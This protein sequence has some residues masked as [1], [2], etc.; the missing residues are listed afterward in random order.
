[1]KKK[2]IKIF[3]LLVSAVIVGAGIFIYVKSN[4]F[5]RRLKS[6][7]TERLSSYTQKQVSIDRIHTDILNRIVLTN[8][9]LKD[10]KTSEKLIK[11]K[12]ARISYSLIKFL[13]KIRNIPEL[14][15]EIHFFEPELTVFYRE[16]QIAV[17]GLEKVFTGSGSEDPLPPWK[18]EFSGGKIDIRHE[19]YPPADITNFRGEL[20]LASYPR[21][22]GDV[23]FNI[24]RST[25]REIIEDLNV[26]LGYNMVSR[27]FNTQL[28]TDNFRMASIES[29]DFLKQKIEFRQGVAGGKVKLEG[30]VDEIIED[31][32]NIKGSGQITLEDTKTGD[33][34]L[35]KMDLNISPERMLI[36]RGV[37]AWKENEFTLS[38]RVNNYLTDPN[39]D[40]TAAGNFKIAEFLPE[41]IA[42]NSNDSVDFNGNFK[43][44]PGEFKIDGDLVMDEGEISGY[45]VENFKTSVLYFDNKINFETGRLEI[46]DGNLMWDGYIKYPSK[47][48][49]L[50][51]DI[52][53]VNLEKIAKSDRFSGVADGKIKLEQ[54]L[55]DPLFEGEINFNN[56]NIYGKTFSTLNSDLQYSNKK[57]TAEGFSVDN[58]YDFG[59]EIEF[60]R[61]RKG[62]VTEFF[63]NMPDR[64][65]LE[66]T[67]NLG[68][69]PFTLDLALTATRVPVD[70][71]SG[72]N[73]RYDDPAGDFNYDGTVKVENSKTVLNGR[74]NTTDLILGGYKYLINTDLEYKAGRGV[75]NLNLTDFKLNE[76]LSGNLKLV[77]ENDGFK[78]RSLNVSAKSVKL[79]PLHYLTGL[80]PDIKE[81][82]LN[83]DINYTPEFGRLLFNVKKLNVEG[84]R[85]GDMYSVIE[86]D[87][88]SWYVEKLNF[89]GSKGNINLEGDLYPRQSLDIIMDKYNFRDRV[90]TGTGYYS[91]EVSKGERY[92]FK[93][94][95]KNLN[96]SRSSWPDITANGSYEKEQLSIDLNARDLINGDFTVSPKTGKNLSG[97]FRVKNLTMGKINTLINIQSGTLQKI[98]GIVEGIFRISDTIQ[99]PLVSFQGEVTGGEWRKV[100]FNLRGKSVYKPGTSLS[101]EETEGRIG[102]GKITAAG[103]LDNKQENELKVEVRNFDSKYLNPDILES[104]KLKAIVDANFIFSGSLDSPRLN[105]DIYSKKFT[106]EGTDIEQVEINGVLQDREF[107]L[108]RAELFKSDG[109]VILSDSNIL[110]NGG[111]KYEFRGRGKFEN[112]IVKPVTILGSTRLNGNFSMSPF[113]IEINLEPENLL[114]NRLKIERPISVEYGKEKL[115]LN[116]KEGIQADV[117]FRSDDKIVVEELNY[118]GENSSIT[119]A[120]EFGTG[121][122]NLNLISKNIE[123]NKFIKIMDSPLEFFGNSDFKVDVRYSED[124]DLK[125]IG[126]MEVRNGSY[127]KIPVDRI[128]GKFNYSNGELHIENAKIKDPNYLNLEIDGAMGESSPGLDVAVKRLSLSV[129]KL[130]TEEI[131]ESSGYF[132]GRFNIGGTLKD[133]DFSGQLNLANG[134]IKGS[135]IIDTIKKINSK[136][137]AEGTKFNVDYLRADWKPGSVE[138]SGFIDI[139]RSPPEVNFNLKSAGDKGV[140]VKVPYLSIPQSGLFGRYLSFPSYGE[141]SFE[142][143]LT[144]EEEF[145][146]V[147]ANITLADTHFTY[148]PLDSSPSAPSANFLDKTILDINLN[149]GKSV[150]YENTYARLKVNGGLNFKKSPG[151]D[152]IVNG[153]VSSNQGK[154]SYL[155]REFDVQE[156]SLSFQDSVEQIEGRATTQVQR[157]TEENTWTTEEI[158]MV[159]PRDRIGN[160]SPRFATG[161][162]GDDT[163]SEQSAEIAIA[164]TDFANLSPDERDNLLRRELL[165]AIDANLTS[166]LVK[167]ILQRTTIIDDA[168]VNVMV[169]GAED[170]QTMK[171]TG[172]GLRLGSN[173]TDRF[174][175][176]YYMELGP[177]YEDKLRLNHE[178]DM[179]YRLQ[180]SQFFRGSIS[181]DRD[182]YFG[183]EQQLKF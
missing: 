121:G 132:T 28:K 143:D 10:K 75:Y 35:K 62:K 52:S 86:Y 54:Y 117:Q 6:I 23:A 122:V 76:T 180:E 158:N 56:L 111:E 84:I 73:E 98:N 107:R 173:L 30:N 22:N 175:M 148:P 150:W 7:I 142:I 164:G 66:C 153:T 171:L 182:I 50:D 1:M 145:Y 12:R 69:A 32:E 109:S 9:S 58:E 131:T 43:G 140:M 135:K 120:G 2:L 71:I 31:I 156:V 178:L 20:S 42:V 123:I 15:K 46:V 68:Y 149:A 49:N 104:D 183:I 96:I 78:I 5:N 166:P 47:Q 130:L 127:K 179:M 65:R 114:L 29:F 33:L 39:L 128:N 151:K 116:V 147:D 144:T 99:E 139:S 106:I 72:L 108:D 168:K 63:M 112:Y 57:L 79:P 38:G 60:S 24:R 44:K 41:D 89:T 8:I 174:S 115:K 146:R 155:N 77:R 40:I 136:I 80:G 137:T 119:G 181:E 74:L 177:G 169:E 87:G 94:E 95:F 159:I 90:L 176:G 134:K 37:L 27:N 157:R 45:K 118:K 34:N 67:G 170:D 124:E 83:G 162:F 129:L 101:V 88:D 100:P 172:A 85:P 97:E 125:A 133:P 61:E 14:I 53:G 81:G 17:K 113:F 36:D 92:N 55:N 16:G 13:K 64:G 4:R 25:G 51:V 70:Q 141:P 21:I 3:I 154:V 163:T 18:F 126:N 26:K 48:V 91:G 93:S 110:F 160:I 138:G 19:N 11:I 103:K 102:N 167:N 165:R 161:E 152:L 59:A 82:V 105:T